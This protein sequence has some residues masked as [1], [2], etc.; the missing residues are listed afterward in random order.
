LLLEPLMDRNLGFHYSVVTWTPRTK[1]M[2][3]QVGTIA[4]N[5][6]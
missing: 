5:R 1:P 3:I 2:G 4:K 6:A